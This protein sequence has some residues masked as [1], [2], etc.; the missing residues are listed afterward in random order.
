MV[1]AVSVALLP[2]ITC[3]ACWPA[4]AALASALGLG[5]VNYGPYLLPL[6]V[7]GLALA[8]AGL[9]FRAKRRRGYGPLA[10]GVVGGVVMMVGKFAYGSQAAMYG[11]IAFLLGASIWNV[12]PKQRPRPCPACVPT[13][14]EGE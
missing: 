7:G 9:A 6:T 2:K 13:G 3:P 10:L 12:W 8:W 1:P 14:T 11:G 5:A 4:Y